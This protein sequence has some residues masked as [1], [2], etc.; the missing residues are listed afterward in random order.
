MGSAATRLSA[1]C[2]PDIVS[3]LTDAF[4]D[5]PVMRFVIGT[6]HADYDRRLHQLVSFIVFRRMRHG[7]PL[8]GVSDEHGHLVGA[9]IMT[10]PADPDSP[11]DVVA[12][13]DALWR[14]VGDDA[15]LRHEAYWKATKPFMT[16]RPHHHLNM[17]GVRTANA[18]T[19]LARQLLD[20]VAQIAR[21]DSGSC[22]VSLTTEVPRNVTLYEHFGYRVTGH[23]HVRPDVETW[24][25]FF[26]IR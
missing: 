9:A 18:G 24:G 6:E 16:D 19:G 7:G 1:D 17:I 22:G 5:Y 25:M 14:D 2:V 12:R 15:R 20:A 13:R 23:A 26:A 3:V 11:G 4:R 21:D 8:L 10:L